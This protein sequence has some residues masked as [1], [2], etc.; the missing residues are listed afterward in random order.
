MSRSDEVLDL[1]RK[2]EESLNGAI[3]LLKNKFC[4]FA[5]SRAYYA[6]LYAAEALPL[7]RGLAFSKHQAVISAFGK[8]FIKTSLMLREVHRHLIDG[9]DLRQAGDYGAATTIST[10]MAS[11]GIDRAITFLLHVKDVLR[12]EGHHIPG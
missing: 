8:E 1:I 6:M 11:E 9:Y 2:S 5:G 10:E 7:T 4:A 3:L 12:K